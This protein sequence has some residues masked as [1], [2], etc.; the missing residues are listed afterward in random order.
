[1]I[2]SN[3]AITFRVVRR[4]ELTEIGVNNFDD[5]GY[6]GSIGIFLIKGGEVK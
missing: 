4:I 1:L 6:K 5:G 2:N 3:P